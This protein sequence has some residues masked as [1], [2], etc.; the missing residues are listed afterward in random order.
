MFYLVIEAISLSWWLAKSTIGGLYYYMRPPKSPTAAIEK[1]LKTYL[2]LYEDNMNL[3]EKNDKLE[4]ELAALRQ[5]V[6][7]F[8][9]TQENEKDQNTL[10]LTNAAIKG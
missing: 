10:S 7:L 5:L 8:P 6:D 9:K 1:E 3:V 4:Q 2:R